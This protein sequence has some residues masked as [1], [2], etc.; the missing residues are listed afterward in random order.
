MRSSRSPTSISR[1]AL[2][3]HS[4]FRPRGWPERMAAWVQPVFADANRRAYS[5]RILEPSAGRGALIAPILA[6]APGAII[7]AVEL[8]PAHARALAQ[9]PVRIDCCD[10][11]TRPAPAQ[12]YDL[13]ISNVPFTEGVE[14]AHVAKVLAESERAIL[15]LP[16]RALHG[17]DRWDAIWSQV[18]VEWWIRREAR[19]IKRPYPNASDD[20]AVIDMRR[21]PGA[22]DLEWWRA[23]A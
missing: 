12:R 4:S 17:G 13:S 19:L 3:S 11:L 21:G 23:A 16:I 14:C 8:D 9:F 22:T 6:R 10:Y 15:Q 7:D 20:I 5:L 2:R 18:G 1:A